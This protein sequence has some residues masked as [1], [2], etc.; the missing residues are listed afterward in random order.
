MEIARVLGDF[1]TLREEGVKRKDYIE[2][3]VEDISSYY[4]YNSYLTRKFLEMFS[5]AE[6]LSFHIHKL[7]IRQSNFSKRMKFPAPSSSAQIPS[8][9]LGEN[10]SMPS[11][12]AA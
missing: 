9:Q 6:V 8:K 2:R 5:V 1:K 10:S 12:H 4:S 11:P 7:T 3:L